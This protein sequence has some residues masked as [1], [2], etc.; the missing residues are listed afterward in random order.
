MTTTRSTTTGRE[1]MTADLE[2]TAT[3]LAAGS[4][5]DRKCC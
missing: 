5:S 1:L 3:A 2:S 4:G